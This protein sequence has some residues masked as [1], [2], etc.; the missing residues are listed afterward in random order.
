MAE[1]QFPEFSALTEND[2]QYFLSFGAPQ[3]YLSK[4]ANELQ[5]ENRF[6]TDFRFQRLL[7]WYAM[8]PENPKVPKCTL[9]AGTILFRA[10]IYDAKNDAEEKTP[11]FQGYGQQ[12][13]FVPL[14]NDIVP[15]GRINPARI[16]YLYTAHSVMTAVAE[17]NPRIKEKVSVAEIKTLKALEILSFC[18]WWTSTP[19]VNGKTNPLYEWQDSLRLAFTRVFNR[20]YQNAGDYLLCQYVS[21]F[22]KNLG[23]DGIA[24]RSSRVKMDPENDRQ[25]INYTIFNYEKCRAISSRL[26]SVKNLTYVLKNE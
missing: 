19:L 11:E 1:I 25:D 14:D 23:Y 2:W 7:Y 9:N 8:R 15:E 13:S 12:G 4:V 5:Y 22:I 24:F 10:R 16:R 20:N 17:V 18:P 6:F 26:F 21:E 3:N